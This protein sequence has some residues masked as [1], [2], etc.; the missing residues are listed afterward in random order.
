MSKGG[1]V[2]TQTQ[3]QDVPDWSQPYY[4]DMLA[5][6][7]ALSEEDYVPYTGSRLAGDSPDLLTS[8]N[9]I[10]N[11]AGQPVAGS[12]EAMGTF[13]TLGG[14][15]G[16]LGRQNPYQFSPYSGFQAAQVSPFAGFSETQVSPFAGFGQYGG[17]QEYG[18]FQ[19]SPDIQAGTYDPTRQFGQSE[20]D[21]YM[22]PYMQNVVQVQQDDAIR[23][24]QQQQAARDASA[25]SAGAFGGSR[26]GVQQGMAEEAL[27][28]QLGAIQAT[29]SQQAFENAQ[30]Q[31][32]RDRMAQMT[33][34]QRQIE[35]FARAQGL[36]VQ[37]AARV[38]QQTAA[39]RARIQQMDAAE[40]ARVQQSQ[41]EELARVQ[42]ITVEEAA[43]V[44]AAQA[45]ELARVQGITVEE[46]AR[47]QAGQAA[48]RARVQQA[49]A[50]EFMRQREFQL[51]T[52]GFSA[53]M[54]RELAMQGER[55]RQ[56]QIQ[57]AQLLEAQ[58]L[59]TMSREQARLD[60]AY[61]DFLR[62]QAYPGQQL[63]MYS[64][65]LYGLPVQGAGTTTA[66]EP[67]NPIQEALG[68]G[69]AGLGL[70][71]GLQR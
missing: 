40:F 17:L 37:E 4:T 15:A 65:N 48:E 3:I 8:Q 26:Q 19:M 35:E 1:Q 67:Y 2:Q 41:A 63:S 61:Q 30:Q 25:V 34:E 6:S 28:R 71:Q 43:R 14:Q 57:N 32:E 55:E 29:G 24:F 62:Q 9:M 58:A 54:A 59:G 23:Q 27:M 10:R 68:A 20:L 31:F 66:Y 64:S 46:A 49:Q 39:E 44:Q 22:S 18:G 47:V 51:Q 5:K 7:K 42:G 16:T 11:I 36:S 53:D 38:Q 33:T 13:R 50:D 52:M 45:A 60:I 69:I 12:Q 56:A 21:A 70:Y